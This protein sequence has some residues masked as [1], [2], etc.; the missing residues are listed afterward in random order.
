M[1][2]KNINNIYISFPPERV[3][4][5][6]ITANIIEFFKLKKLSQTSCIKRPCNFLNKWLSPSVSVFYYCTLTVF[7][8]CLYKEYG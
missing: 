3:K 2:L 4:L 8:I 1:L 7:Y 6:L 5:W